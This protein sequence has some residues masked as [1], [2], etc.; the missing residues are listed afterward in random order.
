[1]RATWRA[2]L[3]QSGVGPLVDGLL[4]AWA[5]VGLKNRVDALAQFDKI[6]EQSGLQGVCTV[7]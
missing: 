6:A 4:S 5:Q 2:R 7:S 3:K 1:M